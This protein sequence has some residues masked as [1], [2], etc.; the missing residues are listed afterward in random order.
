MGERWVKQY[1]V[2]ALAALRKPQADL[3]V[4]FVNETKARQLNARYRGI[5]R[6]AD[7]LSFPTGGKNDLGDIFIAPSSCRQKAKILGLEYREYLAHLIVHGVL[8]LGGYSHGAAKAARRMEKA[9]RRILKE[10]LC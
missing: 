4:V 3:S 9:E 10:R 2:R 6:P 1:A 7:I 5:R 8:H